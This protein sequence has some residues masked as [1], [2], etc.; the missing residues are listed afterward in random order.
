MAERSINGTTLYYEERGSGLPVVLMHGFPLDHRIWSAQLDELSGQYRVIVP[1][2]RGFGRSKSNTPFTMKSLAED[3]CA[4][5]R[6]INAIP[7]VLGGLSMGGYVA[8]A[9]AKEYQNDLRGLMLIDTRAEADTAEGKAGRQKM[10][11]L[12][13]TGGSKAV[14]DQM[15]PKMLAQSTPT[16]QPA[17][18]QQL[19]Q[20]MEACP[21][22]T[23]EHALAAMRD[24][25]D[26]TAF[27][28]SIAGP[29]L[30]IV[31]QEDAITPPKMAEA[32][33]QQIPRSKLV[34]IPGSGHMS[35]M[36]KPQDV[37]RAMQDF[38]RQ[39]G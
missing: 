27:L 33:N 7:C 4:L 21:P 24:R 9:F 18:A 31:G 2:L 32:M 28:P 37:T 20:I 25:E 13:R 8:L 16:D 35:P 30:I 26:Y 6:A 29:T 3:I 36:E 12:A 1:D 15:M 11:D 17:V 38:L 39:V 10:I 14:A 23:I 5:L 19:R 22:L 34:V